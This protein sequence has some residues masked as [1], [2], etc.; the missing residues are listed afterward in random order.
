MKRSE[1]EGKTVPAIVRL[2]QL[3]QHLPSILKSEINL[4]IHKEAMNSA[5]ILKNFSN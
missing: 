5:T 1:E 3:V 2:K 4:T